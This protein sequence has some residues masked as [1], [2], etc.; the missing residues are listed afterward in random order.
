MAL[1]IHIPDTLDEDTLAVRAHELHASGFNCA[2]SVICVLGPALG[3]DEDL[4][5][6]LA[7]GLGA[8][9]G[10]RTETCG[11]LLGAAMAV[12]LA[13]SNGCADPTTKGAT[14]GL[15]A[16]LTAA[17]AEKYGTTTCSALRAQDATGEMPLSICADCIDTALAGAVD[18]LESLHAGE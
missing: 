5:F 17:F 11:A 6:R 1:D 18:V 3:A 15:V 2:Q 9:L 14:Y 10:G 8:G 16:P 4:C 13:R 12:G 7:E